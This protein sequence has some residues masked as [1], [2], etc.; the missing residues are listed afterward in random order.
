MKLRKIAFVNQII[1]ANVK[2]REIS[3]VEVIKVCNGKGK[4]CL[5][6]QTEQV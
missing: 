5:G 2:K 1:F 6:A 3:S 4:C